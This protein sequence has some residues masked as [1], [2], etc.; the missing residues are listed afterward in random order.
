VALGASMPRPTA[1]S[2]SDGVRP[3]AAHSS[4][5]DQTTTRPVPVIPMSL[6][7][8]HAGTSPSLRSYSE[9]HEISMVGVCPVVVG[10]FTATP[11]NR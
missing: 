4:S 5:W 8:G 2:T 9:I 6:N 7:V 1:S 3:A 10:V 11:E